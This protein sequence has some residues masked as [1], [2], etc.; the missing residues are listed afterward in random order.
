MF[1]AFSGFV[2]DRGYDRVLRGVYNNLYNS[3]VASFSKLLATELE[4]TPAEWLREDEDAAREAWEAHYSAV[5]SEWVYSDAYQTPEVAR[6]VEDFVSWHELMHDEPLENYVV[7]DIIHS[8]LT[9]NPKFK[10]EYPV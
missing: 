6:L 9:T 2:F 1:H 3:A 10:W 4:K 7:M 8:Y 5:V